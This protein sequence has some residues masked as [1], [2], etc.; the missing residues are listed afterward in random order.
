M[1]WAVII[2]YPGFVW[3]VKYANYS[4]CRF[5]EMNKPLFTELAPDRVRWRSFTS[6]WGM[7]IPGSGSGMWLR[8]SFRLRSI[9]WPISQLVNSNYQSITKDH[10][11]QHHIISNTDL[12]GHTLALLWSVSPP[13]ILTLFIGSIQW[14]SLRNP[15][16]HENGKNSRY[17]I[18]TIYIGDYIYIGGAQKIPMKIVKV[19]KMV[20]A[21]SW[22]VICVPHENSD[23]EIW[24]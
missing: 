10:I 24:G 3:H 9:F 7:S 22:K 13:T 1:L 15:R 12:N 21:Y 6:S 19:V 17:I 4:L 8:F 23:N 11:F 18:Y 14:F 2:N 16:Y 5:F 20:F